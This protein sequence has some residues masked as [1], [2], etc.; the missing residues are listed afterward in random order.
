MIFNIS[1][2]QVQA[3]KNKARE[4]YLVVEHKNLIGFQVRRR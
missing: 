2:F 4:T 1:R 3:W